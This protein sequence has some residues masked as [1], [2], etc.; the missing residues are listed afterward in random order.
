[1]LIAKS[2]FAVF[3]REVKSIIS[4]KLYLTSLVILPAVMLLFFVIFFHRGSINDLPIAIIDNDHSAISRELISMIDTTRGVEVA[5][6]SNSVIEAQ[7]MVLGGDIYGY[8][9]IPHG[10]ENDIIEGHPTAVDVEISG[11][12]LSAAGV[13]RAN[14]QQVV[15][16]LSS[17]AAISRLMSLGVDEYEALIDVMPINTLTHII[18][19][20][21]L[22]Y[23]YYLAP[24]FMLVGIVLFTMLMTI[25]AIGRELRYATAPEWLSVASNSLFS[26]LVGK[27]LPITIVMIFAMEFAFLLL[28]MVMGIE[29]AGSHIVLLLVSSLLIVAYQSIAIA[30][31]AITANMRL[32]LSLGGGYAVMAFTFSGVTFPTMA[33]YTIA[34]GFSH[35]FPFT[36]YCKFFIS[37]TM[38]GSNIDYSYTDIMMIMMFI[39]ISALVWRRLSR[40]VHNRRYWGKD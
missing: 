15:M 10:F 9:V 38:I 21:Y 8:V 4:D 16:T 36:Y 5:Y 29:F 1:M 11:A 6:S 33:M 7:S 13:L 18:A 12:N 35:I 19:N 22:N 27:L 24:I 30:I 14:I 34:R 32:A 37:Y 3:K 2:I 28:S 26:A 17:G 39:L 40:V 23:G 20:P 25:Y 31:V